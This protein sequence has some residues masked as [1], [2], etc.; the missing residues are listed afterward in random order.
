MAS[1]I[2]CVSVGGSY[3]V[4]SS[5]YLQ[6]HL[7]GV[8]YRWFVV[9]LLIQGFLLFF[10]EA[11]ESPPNSIVLISPQNKRQWTELLAIKFCTTFFISVFRLIQ[12]LLHVNMILHFAVV[13]LI[14]LSNK[15][16]NIPT[17]SDTD[18]GETSSVI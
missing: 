10:S 1:V 3:L 7:T 14:Y 18:A 8:A 16:Y 5:V 12:F 6:I 13:V 2:S 9:F 4:N 17:D 11:D 15:A